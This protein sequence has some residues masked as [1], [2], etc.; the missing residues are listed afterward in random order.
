MRQLG[1]LAS[2]I[3]ILLMTAGC[4]A[5]ILAHYDAV[6]LDE[7][8]EHTFPL[9]SSRQEVEARL[10]KPETSRLL[11]DGSQAATYNYTI[12]NPEWRQMKWLAALGTV[13]TVGF[14]EP[15]SLP[16]A[17]YE[18]L[19]HQR[20]ATLRYGPDDALLDHGLPPAYGPPDDGLSSLSFE[21]IRELCRS[22]TAE[23]PA[24]PAGSAAPPHGTYSYQACVVRR[25]AIWGIE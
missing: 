10:G 21:T 8:A 25:L 4:G 11:P 6:A 2:V 7:S 23:G 14:F 12:R 15:F 22:D 18:V 1:V 17:S 24:A 3:G 5:A 20:T 19:K 13:I 9:G 16:F